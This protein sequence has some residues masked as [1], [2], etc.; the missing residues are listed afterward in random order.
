MTRLFFLAAAAAATLALTADAGDALACGGC[1]T[2]PI[3]Q[4][5]NPS[6]VTGHR[7]VLSISLQQTTLYDQI[8]YAGNPAE[9][10]WVLPINGTVTVG[11]S[12]DALF[13]AL[14]KAT[15]VRV[16]SPIIQCPAALPCD[17]VAVAT[18]AGSGPG[19]GELSTG[20]VTVL[21]QQTVGPYETVQLSATKPTALYDWLSGHGYA[22]PAD[23][24]PIIDAYV[25][26]KSNFLALKLVP[27]AGVDAMRPVRITSPGASPTLPMRMVAAG[28]GKTT[29]ITLWVIGDGRYQPKNAPS[30]IIGAN[31]LTWD[32]DTQ[33]SDYVAVRQKH[34]D[35]AQGLAYQVEVSLAGTAAYA[36]DQLTI[37]ANGN[38]AGSGYDVDKA[39]E[40]VKD[41]VAALF[42]STAPT[43][44][45]VTR[46]RGELSR[47]AFASDL[48]LEAAAD[49]SPVNDF[50]QVT[51]TKGT[52]PSCPAVPQC[53]GGEGGYAASSASSAHGCSWAT[54]EDDDG[55]AALAALALLGLAVGWRRV[56]TRR[57]V[58]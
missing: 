27:G 31:E 37:L 32:W 4:S 7:M 35:A 45:V 15:A 55:G 11:L 46:L 57:N 42:G 19:G 12:S 54:S 9:F 56:A 52:P 40:Q 51:K 41:E 50:L 10:G 49:Q 29:T 39:P 18:T 24:K 53:G 33:S 26:Q 3:Q 1:F 38:P 25:A 20:S 30:F 14:D 34:Y 17:A 47:N 58:R 8:T 28:T 16:S 13:D 21:A 23:V 48:L 43:E 22:V 44:A 6:Q 5:Q 36:A 2:P